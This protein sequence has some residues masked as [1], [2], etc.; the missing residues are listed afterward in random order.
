MSAIVL[1]KVDIKKQS[2]AAAAKSSFFVGTFQKADG[3][4]E[5]H[6]LEFCN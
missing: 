4:S 1:E 2:S 6:R 3:I 5:T